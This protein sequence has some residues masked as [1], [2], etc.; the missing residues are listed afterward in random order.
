MIV[1]KTLIFL[2][3][4]LASCSTG[5]APSVM[6]R[7]YLSA[8]HWD[9]GQAEVN[10]YRVDCKSCGI[11]SET[12]PESSFILGAYLV[13][14]DYD[15]VNQTKTLTDDADRVTAFK[16][17]LF[18]EYGSKYTY[19][20]KFAFIVNMLKSNLRPLKRSFTSFDWC[21][22]VY[23]E[24]TV[25][26]DGRVRRIYRSDDYGNK[27]GRFSY[28][29]GAFTMEQVPFLVRALDFS[30]GRALEFRIMTPEGEF[31]MTRASIAGR[32]SVELPGEGA[33]DAEKVRI[34]YDKLVPPG[35]GKRL[36]SPI[37]RFADQEE[38]Y[39]RGTGPERILLKMESALYRM[40]LVDHIRTRYWSHDKEDF[41]NHMKN[42]MELP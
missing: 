10:F 11:G 4:L 41:F 2:L 37:G 26:L 9:D 35:S 13:K 31:I 16:W 27:D 29:P 25:S 1:L 14:H 24:T 15:P 20:A 19:E 5:D 21:S 23:D 33:R 34:R 39:W 28:L 6:D 12:L 7:A 3:A 17:A 38:F 40:V 36:M 32:E 22:N 18:Y 8:P 30:G 42:V